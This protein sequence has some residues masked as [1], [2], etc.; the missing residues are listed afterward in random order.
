MTISMH[1]GEPNNAASTMG[2]GPGEQP[3]MFDVAVTSE[4]D[5]I[6]LVQASGCVRRQLQ[7]Q[8]QEI[9][10]EKLVAKEFVKRYGSVHPER[11]I[12]HEAI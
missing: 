2:L 7:P 1:S 4:R 5:T 9:P 11:Y 8:I 3:N 10:S 6:F 12:W